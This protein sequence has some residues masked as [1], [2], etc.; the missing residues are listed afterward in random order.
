MSEMTDV[1]MTLF[2]TPHHAAELSAQADLMGDP[3]CVEPYWTRSQLFDAVRPSTHYRNEV[4]DWLR[5]R[6]IEPIALEKTPELAIFLR[7]SREAFREAFG[8]RA[9]RWLTHPHA[10]RPR[11][12]D[13]QIPARLTGYV[14]G[15][16][17]LR[18]TEKV[19]DWLDG[20]RFVTQGGAEHH[21][22]Q[23]PVA[24]PGTMPL[25]LRGMSP[26]D[27]GWIYDFPSDLRGGH[28]LGVQTRQPA[29]GVSPLLLED[30]EP[31]DDRK[32][33]GSGETIA[34]L[35][36][37]A[38]PDLE[39]CQAFWQAHGIDR[40]PPQVVHIGPAPHRRPDK[41]EAKEAAMG[42]QWAGAMAPGAR[43]VC[44]VMDRAIIADKWSTWLMGLI[45]DRTWRPTI[46]ATAW[47]IAERDY[48]AAYDSRIITT[49]LDQCAVLGLTVVAAAGNWG[50][51]DG[52][53]RTEVR[54]IEGVPAAPWPATVFPACEERVLG[55]GG[56][57]ITE[58]DPLTELAWSGPLP[59]KWA[60]NPS[61]STVSRMGGGGGFST[62]VPIPDYQSFQ[63]TGN[64]RGRLAYFRGPHAP[65]VLAFGRGVPDVSLM[66]VA[67]SVQREPKAPP[68]ARGYRAVVQGRWIDFAG[69]TSVAAPIWAAL[70]ARINQARRALGL[71][72]VGFANPLL[73]RIARDFRYEG[74]ASGPFRDIVAGRTDV[75]M[76]SV[77][78]STLDRTQVV[79]VP[80]ELP[81]FEA[82]PFWD[83]ATGLGVPRGARLCREV[84]LRGQA[85]VRKAGAAAAE[86]DAE[87]RAASA[88]VSG[89]RPAAGEP[90]QV[91]PGAGAGDGGA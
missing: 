89:V 55:V 53:P 16:Q 57:M 14:Q 71:R 90:A 65:P 81:G 47:L 73:Y 83:P 9:H 32:L 69:G 8:E 51:Y 1:F 67:D 20:S 36:L 61:M 82:G 70:L 10:E 91:D 68:T 49:L 44:Y 45:N 29:P 64:G 80:I 11:R 24:G 62:E 5:Q 78:S 85:A 59:P 56:T 37:D 50:C 86:A 17:V 75:T 58:R 7:C 87:T 21:G 66:A 63:V 2:W 38:E 46:A 88:A 22:V 43:I 52:V 35:L 3:D 6:G 25:G 76:R 27:I 40:E 39:D 30:G 12:I 79:E 54:G 34:L 84:V 33:D 13:W 18:D 28:V 19:R 48:Y 31:P 74:A 23:S 42:V 72:R 77:A 41:M 60:D 15:I 26:D 4:L